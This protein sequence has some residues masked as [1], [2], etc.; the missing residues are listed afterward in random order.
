LACIGWG[1]SRGLR[2]RRSE[3]TTFNPKDVR[4]DDEMC[5]WQGLDRDSCA[6]RS[7]VVYHQ[8]GMQMFRL[9]E[10]L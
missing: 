5:R 4:E 1:S 3:K 9:D 7:E 10:G 2:I 8:P 6:S